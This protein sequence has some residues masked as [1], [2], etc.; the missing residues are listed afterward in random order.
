MNTDA[1][2]P[3]WDNSKEYLGFDDQAMRLDLASIEAI[4]RQL[5]EIARSITA[6]ISHAEQLEGATLAHVVTAAQEATRLSEKAS[7]LLHNVRT[8]AE[9][10]LSVDGVNAAAKDM[11]GLLDPLAA[12]LQEALSPVTQFL[13]RTSDTGVAAF[14]AAPDLSHHRFA[15]S[16]QRLTKPHT[17]SL[18]EESLLISLNVNG[19]NAFGRLYD[20]I[21]TT[22][23]CELQLEQGPRKMGV[24][25]ASSLLQD[26]DEKTRKTAYLAIKGGWQVHQ[27]SIAAVLNALAGWRL[28]LCRKRSRQ[29]V[30]HF[31]DTP[32]HQNHIQKATLDA[33][34]AVVEESKNT[35]Q[36]VLRLQA[37]LMNKKRLGPWDLFA[38]CPAPTGA[39]TFAPS[40]SEALAITRQAFFEVDPEMGEFVD[41]MQKHR[42]IDARTGPTRKPGA[43]C[44]EFSKS[45]TPRVFMTY[46]GGTR[47][48]ITLAHEL[49]HAFH[50]YVLRDAPIIETN[51]PM[52]LAETASILAQSLVNDTLLGKAE[53]DADKLAFTW[54][55][56]RE[57]EAFLLNIPARFTFERELYERREQKPLPPEELKRLMQSHWQRW[58]GD[59]L[60]EMDEMFWASKL[61]FSISSLSFYNFPYTFGYLFSLG[62]LAQRAKLGAKFYPAY[63]ALL[64]DTGRMSAEDL[65]A[66]HLGVDLTQKNFWRDSVSIATRAKD[67]FA[68]AVLG[69]LKQ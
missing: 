48:L 54:G 21:A 69:N 7:I 57:L 50:A 51:Y 45:R 14:L 47:E 67:R 23:E 32:L 1:A 42:Y 60:S 5:D 40:Y 15:V 35:A 3:T 13:I 62:V 16:H 38:P 66:K 29:K 31:L 56:A 61:H 11:I 58:Y 27:E 52:S 8:F 17:L 18:A 10:E 4:I 37:K 12:R 33:M 65:A 34:L 22:I 20:N 53:T 68:E 39:S 44:T 19:P 26:K 25:S 24:A 46:S 9:C 28:D 36:E 63:V 30:M 6:H 2:L 55:A 49:G 41:Y 59:T 43:Y 64:R